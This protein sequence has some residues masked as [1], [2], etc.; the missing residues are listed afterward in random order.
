M[1]YHLSGCFSSSSA[2][3]IFRLCIWLLIK[4]T[5]SRSFSV[6]F[7]R[8]RPF[9]KC[10]SAFFTCVGNMPTL[11]SQS[12][13]AFD[14][15]LST[16]CGLVTKWPIVMTGLLKI[17]LLFVLAVDDEYEFVR[18]TDDVSSVDSRQSVDRVELCG[19]FFF[20]SKSLHR[21]YI[22]WVVIDMLMACFCWL[23]VVFESDTVSEWLVIRG[24]EPVKSFDI[25]W[26]KQC[27]FGLLCYVMSGIWFYQSA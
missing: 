4:N 24:N 26:N 11:S 5:F 6:K 22:D 9:F 7:K 10:F 13:I 15:H 23:F 14:C 21:G 19:F 20:D 2:S 16:S 12:L 1:G 25:S 18:H 27:K 17:S 8:D 3:L